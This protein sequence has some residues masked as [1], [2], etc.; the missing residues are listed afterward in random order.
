MGNGDGSRLISLSS[1][2]KKVHYAF[3]GTNALDKAQSFL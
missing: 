1:Q 2:D 3:S